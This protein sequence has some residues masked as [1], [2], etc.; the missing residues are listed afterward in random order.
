MET[1]YKCRS[2]IFCVNIL[3][4]NALFYYIY[5]K[6]NS[7][8]SVYLCWKNDAR[9]RFQVFQDLKIDTFVGKFTK[10]VLNWFVLDIGK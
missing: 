3:C 6:R 8:K 5:E 4:I 10:S 9:V 2:Y 7:K 1:E